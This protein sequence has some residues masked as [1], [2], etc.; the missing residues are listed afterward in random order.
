MKRVMQIYGWRKGVS[1]VKLLSGI[2]LR[3]HVGLQ[4]TQNL[5]IY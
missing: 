3:M 5:R 1:S 4:T 2:G